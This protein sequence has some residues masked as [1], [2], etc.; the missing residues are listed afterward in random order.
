MLDK[1]SGTYAP[2]PSNGPHKLREALPLV[3]SISPFR[4]S[5]T[6]PTWDHYLEIQYSRIEPVG[7]SKHGDGTAPAGTIAALGDV[8]HVPLASG[9]SGN[10]LVTVL[11]PPLVE[12]R[13]LTVTQ[14]SFFA[15]IRSSSATA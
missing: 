1:L 15:A 2:R 11:Y 9:S 8:L 14:F 10:S 7:G 3:V 4:N 12:P 13:L 6:T 5:T